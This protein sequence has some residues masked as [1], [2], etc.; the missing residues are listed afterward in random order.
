MKRERGVEVRTFVGAGRFQ[1]QAL[2]IGL[3]WPDRS[4]ALNEEVVDQLKAINESVWEE[5]PEGSGLIVAR[6]VFELPPEKRGN[7]LKKL[8]NHFQVKK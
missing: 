3:N 5:I 4:G 6:V 2:D 8:L 1:H 7:F